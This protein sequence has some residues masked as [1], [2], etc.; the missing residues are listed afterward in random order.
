MNN[1]VTIYSDIQSDFI[2]NT[3]LKIKFY[4]WRKKFN[5]KTDKML[6]VVKYILYHVVVNVK[7]LIVFSFKL[8]SLL[9]LI[10]QIS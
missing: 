9:C 3:V 8:V 7:N 10:L 5:S 4:E 6:E 1:F 2:L